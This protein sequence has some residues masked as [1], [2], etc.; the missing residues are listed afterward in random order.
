MTAR[1]YKVAIWVGGLAL[2]AAALIDTG[3][4]LARNLMSSLH[5]SIELI[6]AAVLI[7]GALALAI[8]VASHTYARVHLITERLG[9][10]AK[11]W[12]DRFTAITVAAFFLCLLT[13]S[14]WIAADL[15]HGQ[16]L[17]E[18]IG[19]PWRWMRLFANLCLLA[20]IVILLRQCWRPKR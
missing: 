14:A 7:A 17:S 20:A 13:G 5:G 18:V 1:L 19:V 6:Q 4:V 11:L 12:L 15:W 3:A 10:S 8:A 9:P 2:L 16:E